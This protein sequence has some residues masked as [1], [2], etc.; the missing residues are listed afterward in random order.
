M[1]IIIIIIFL[2]QAFA[3]QNIYSQSFHKLIVPNTIEKTNLS[4]E[5]AKKISDSL[6]LIVY[7]HSKL[8]LN[9][10]Y[11]SENKK[12]ND[13]IEING[14]SY[15]LDGKYLSFDVSFFEFRNRKYIFMS[16]YLSEDVLFHD[17]AKGNYL[18]EITEKNKVNKYV[19]KGRYVDKVYFEDFNQ[20]GI[21]DFLNLKEISF[22]DRFLK[23]IPSEMI[24][25]F[26]YFKIT[27]YSLIGNS[28]QTLNMSSGE[29]YHLF[30]AIG[31]CNRGLLEPALIILESKWF[32]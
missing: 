29:P 21:L 13:F 32:F 6:F 24:D 3:C 4:R 31:G 28:F 2:S 23:K 16:S 20:D 26:T 12:S 10:Y 15:L 9:Y 1:R 8:Q 14:T 7:N 27:C 11:Y 19:F 25:C 18:F 30:C 22:N 17:G 5:T